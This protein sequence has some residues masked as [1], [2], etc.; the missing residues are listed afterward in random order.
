[1]ADVQRIDAALGLFLERKMRNFHTN[2]RGQVIAVNVGGPSVDVQPLA[3]TDFD[4]GT[5]DK[6]PVIYDVPLQLP[7]GNK[8]KAR[9]S[10]PVKPGDIVGLSFSERNESSKQD[11]QTHGLFAGWAV[12]EVFTDGNSKPIHPDNVVL[13][14]D[15]IKIDMTPEGDYILTTPQSTFKI[16]KD[17]TFEFDN[18]AMKIAGYPDGTGKL[19]NGSG[20]MNLKANGEIDT[21]G[22]KIT[23]DGNF[24]TAQGVDLN[25]FW[26]DYIAHRHSGVEPGGGTSGTKV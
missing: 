23:Q 24:I 18:G 9:L 17:G 12:T 14:N 20:G 13:E 7:S 10:M 11:K 25:A 4:D 3:S 6:Y 1:M 26:Q 2:V 5:I 22:G 21:N 8:G 16:L 15:K 19:S